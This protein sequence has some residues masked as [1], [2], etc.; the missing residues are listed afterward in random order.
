ML[1]ISQ[2]Y[3][4]LRLCSPLV[5]SPMFCFRSCSG[6]FC[7]TDDTVMWMFF[8]PEFLIMNG[9]HL[10]LENNGRFSCCQAGIRR[11]GLEDCGAC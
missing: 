7:F 2:S 6:R 10:V 9:P 1:K 4:Q 11:T 3:Y 8:Y 5:V